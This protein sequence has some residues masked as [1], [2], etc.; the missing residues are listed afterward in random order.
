MAMIGHSTS[1]S[2]VHTG[3]RIISPPCVYVDL[4]VAGAVRV[5]TV[6]ADRPC[7]AR[8]P[9]HGQICMY[10][11]IARR[12]ERSTSS[13]YTA[14]SE[15]AAHAPSRRAVGTYVRTVLDI[16]GHLLSPEGGKNAGPNS[17]AGG[18]V[19]LVP[20]AVDNNETAFCNMYRRM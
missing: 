15:T 8:H 6:P 18:D 14:T 11:C 20:I 2:P 9:H 3:G 4:P 10:V 5:Q 12:A 7:L 16:S 17:A 19:E 1:L 13:P